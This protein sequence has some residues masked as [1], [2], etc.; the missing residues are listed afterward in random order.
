MATRPLIVDVTQHAFNAA[1]RDPR[2]PRL[3]WLELAG[4]SLSVSVL[5]PPEPMRFSDE[6]ELLGQLLPGVDGLIIEDLG[7]RALFLPS[8]W[9]EL[10][11]QRQFLIALKL[12]AGLGAGHFSPEFRAQRFRSIEVKGAIEEGAG[13]ADALLG[14]TVL[15]RPT[16]GRSDGSSA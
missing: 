8:V 5:T 1:F 15:P 12:K 6:A 16:A 13:A 10:A 7:R 11:D 4:L 3:D 2:F 9:E 14:W